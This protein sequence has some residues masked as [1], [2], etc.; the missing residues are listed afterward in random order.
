MCFRTGAQ[1]IMVKAYGGVLILADFLLLLIKILYYIGEGI[2][3]LFVP[4]EEKSV[5][6]EIVLVWTTSKH[7]VACLGEPKE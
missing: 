7:T 4:A 6:G 5:A 3:R 1:G 2:Y